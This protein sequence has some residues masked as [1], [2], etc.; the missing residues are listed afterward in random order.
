MEHFL[1]QYIINHTLLNRQ[2][3]LIIPRILIILNK[4]YTLLFS[5]FVKYTKIIYIDFS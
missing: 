1:L 4:Y 2:V 5:V 3:L